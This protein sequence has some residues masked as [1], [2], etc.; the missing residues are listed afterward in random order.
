[1][2]CVVCDN[3]KTLSKKYTHCPNDHKVCQDC[4]LQILKLCFCEKKFGEP[5]YSCPMCR[6]LHRFGNKEMWKILNELKGNSIIKI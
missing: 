5:I 6:N 1:M 2:S 3:E 4:Y